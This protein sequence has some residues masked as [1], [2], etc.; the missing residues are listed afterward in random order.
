MHSDLCTCMLMYMYMNMYMYMY[1][2]TLVQHY[3]V[4]SMGAD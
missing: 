4:I 3:T 1:V 2:C